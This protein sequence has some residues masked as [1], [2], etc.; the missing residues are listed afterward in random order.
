[1]I[2]TA[3]KMYSDTSDKK[4]PDTYSRTL[5]DYHLLLWSKPLP[6]GVMFKLTMK[7]KA[8]YYLYHSSDLGDFRLASDNII[9]TY[10]RWK[11]K[12]MVEIINQIPKNDIDIFFD[13]AST[14]G[15]YVIFPANRIDRKPTINGIRG[16]DSQIYDRFDLTL[17]CI[18]RWYNGKESPLSTHLDRYSSFFL[19]FKDFRGYLEYFLL[20]D[21]VDTDSGNVR[22]WLPF[23]DFGKTSPLPA[24]V[25]EYKIYMKNVLKFTKSRNLR[26]TEWAKLNFDQRIN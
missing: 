14:I 12:S 5:C 24:N 9:H 26:I 7:Q 20:D 4:D 25:D 23:S 22:F 11:R 3:F 2:D 8:P 17:E 15:G 21:L 18:R 6:N 16:I 13:L 10:S 1:M 19:L